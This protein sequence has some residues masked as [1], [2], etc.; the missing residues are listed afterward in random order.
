MTVRAVVFDFD[1]VIANS[2]P[3]HFAAF[4]AVLAEKGIALSE[5]EYY[6][7]YLG[8]DDAGTYA[9]VTRDRG[10]FWSA[11]DIAALVERKAVVYEELERGRSILFPGAREAIGRLAAMC[12]LGI[13]SGSIRAEIVRVLDREDLARHFAAVVSAEDTAASKPAPDPYLRVVDRLAHATGRQL[14]ASECVAVE[15]SPWGIDSA[16]AA[17][18]RSVG[19]SHTYPVDALGSADAVIGRLDELTWEFLGSLFIFLNPEPKTR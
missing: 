18:L 12:P 5:S 2:E 16:R 14:A 19:V 15:D 13:A 8:F 4:R 1:G 11:D 6:A 7:Q 9:A 10:I 3:L 17:G